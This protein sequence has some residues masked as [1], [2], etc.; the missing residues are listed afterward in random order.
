[1]INE[2]LLD[3]LQV[4]TG[5]I[6]EINTDKRSRVRVEDSEDQLKSPWLDI[7]YPFTGNNSGIYLDPTLDTEVLY[8]MFG[9]QSGFVMGQIYNKDQ[10]L[11]MA[12]GETNQIVLKIDANNKII[13]DK[14]AKTI[15]A[16]LDEFTIKG[17]N[18]LTLDSDTIIKIGEAAVSSILKGEDWQSLINTFLAVVV[19]HTHNATV[20]AD[21]SFTV[22]W[23]SFQSGQPATL[24]T[25]SKVE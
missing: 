16:Q 22:P 19:A 4:H 1:M 14:S 13:I 2:S 6:I 23:A 20:G 3:L 24:S 21:T 18:D 17:N 10:A 12:S 25:L 8:I 15:T 7:I 9:E 5:K 11:P